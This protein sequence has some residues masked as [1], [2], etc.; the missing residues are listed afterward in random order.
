MGSRHRVEEHLIFELSIPDR[1]GYSLPECDVPQQDLEK[2]IPPSLLR[3]EL[4]LPEVSEVDVVRHFTGLSRK[5]FGV[6]SGFYPLGS[7]TM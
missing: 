6:D 1:K 4:N 7:C 2:L 5:N 3:K